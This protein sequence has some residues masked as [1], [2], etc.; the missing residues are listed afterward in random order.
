MELDRLN[1]NAC[2]HEEM[3]AALKCANAN[4]VRLQA[5]IAQI[6]SELEEIK[7]QCPRPT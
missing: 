4:F 5:A 1:D 6:L 2:N 3:R 7:R